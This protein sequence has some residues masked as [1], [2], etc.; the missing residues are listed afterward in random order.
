MSDIPAPPHAFSA[1]MQSLLDSVGQ[2]DTDVSNL[3][4]FEF[5][6]D[7]HAVRCLPHPTDDARFVVECEATTLD[8]KQ[9]GDPALMQLLHQLNAASWLESGWTAMLDAQGLCFIGQT[10]ALADTP[11][12]RL[13]EMI[14][15][16]VDRA[17]ALKEIIASHDRGLP[18]GLD[19][20]A[21]FRMFN[22]RA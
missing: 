15:D 3:P 1:M 8:A 18:T 16:A 7:G 13:E 20:Q 14:V 19:P 11:A 9:M 4:G 2:G 10:A 5:E 17:A 12:R 22:Q 21:A 6:S